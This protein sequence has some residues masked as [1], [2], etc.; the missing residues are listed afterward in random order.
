MPERQ[1][2][3]TSI[4]IRLFHETEEQAAENR[5]RLKAFLGATAD[6]R[7]A[8]CTVRGVEVRSAFGLPGD[9]REANERLRA[10]LD[11]AALGPHRGQAYLRSSG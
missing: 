3:V 8:D 10:I 9:R 7:D 2:Q 4:F 1:E 11:C 5:R 6:L